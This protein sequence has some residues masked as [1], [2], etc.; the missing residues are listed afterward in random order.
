MWKFFKNLYLYSQ[1]P[2]TYPFMGLLHVILAKHVQKRIIL[3][4]KRNFKDILNFHIMQF[5]WRKALSESQIIVSCVE[6]FVFRAECSPALTYVK[7]CL[8]QSKWCP[9]KVKVNLLN[10]SD[11][12]RIW[13]LLKG[14]MSLAE[15]GPH[16]GKVNQECES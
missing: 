16:Y 13:D 7:I 5:G 15:V 11:K 3:K 9:N 12:V 14:N 6:I 4:T 2:H 1:S 10:L 8:P